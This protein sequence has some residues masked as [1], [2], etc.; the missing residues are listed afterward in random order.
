MRPRARTRRGWGAGNAKLDGSVFAKLDETERRLRAEG[1]WSSEL[2]GRLRDAYA[3]VARKSAASL[4]DRWVE[5]ASSF[6]RR[7]RRFMNT[8]RRRLEKDYRKGLRPLDVFVAVLVDLGGTIE[9]P[10]DASQLDREV[11]EV[12]RL[13]HARCCRVLREVVWLAR[14]GYPLGA[15]ARARTLH[16]ISVVA[17][18]LDEFSDAEP[19]LPQRYL[20]H[21]FIY[22]LRSAKGDLSVDAVERQEL[23]ARCEA[24]VDRYGTG[25]A[26]D[27]GWAVPLVSGN[28]PGLRDLE[29]LAALDDA[30]V[31]YSWASR[32]VH[33]DSLGTHMNEFERQGERAYL[34]GATN[35]GQVE[36][37]TEAVR[38]AGITTVA[39][40]SRT[41]RQSPSTHMA[42][43][44]LK[45]LGDQ[46]VEGL[47]D[48]DERIIEREQRL[49]DR[50]RRG[51]SP[52]R[53]VT[54]FVTGFARHEP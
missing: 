36:P 25:Y 51:R 38:S 3:E 30:R 26:S 19:T 48:G 10:E 47:N 27:F 50:L 15:N 35:L 6:L 37:L 22:L 41:M 32:E 21:R 46:I 9:L 13:L 8:F 42:V 4:A 18:V 29:R 12:L 54:D 45:V 1:R 24:L 31:S 40:A 39:L 20:D 52:L 28:K 44:A 53:R 5:S 33:A 14:G 43:L 16:E 34:A 2:E 11:F 49:E 23:E 17:A 7:D